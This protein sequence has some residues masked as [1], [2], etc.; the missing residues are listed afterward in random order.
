MLPDE[1]RIEGREL[2]PV[3]I[4]PPIET[5]GG[6]PL[7]LALLLPRSRQASISDLRHG[8]MAKPTRV[9]VY[10]IRGDGPVLERQ[11]TVADVSVALWG[12]VAESVDALR[13][14]P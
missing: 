5:V 9:F 2:V 7:V 11:L 1:V 14:R 8:P 6:D 10:R 4:N 3:S 12:L 13:M